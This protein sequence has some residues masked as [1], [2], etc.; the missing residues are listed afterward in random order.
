MNTACVVYGRFVLGNLTG[1]KP[2]VEIIDTSVVDSKASG[3]ASKI[4]QSEN[5]AGWVTAQTSVSFNFFFFVF[6]KSKKS[7]M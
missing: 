3:S 1:E 7:C 6:W 4:S 5:D 2:E